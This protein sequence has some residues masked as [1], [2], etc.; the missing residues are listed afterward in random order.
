M[1]VK[2]SGEEE[3]VSFRFWKAEGKL[4]QVKK[5]N[6]SNLQVLYTKTIENNILNSD[7]KGQMLK[8]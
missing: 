3:Q 6:M 4:V 5:Q 2:I 8:V 7:A 1:M